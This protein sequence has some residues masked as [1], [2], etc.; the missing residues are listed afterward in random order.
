MVRGS[1]GAWPS[2]PRATNAACRRS[3]RRRLRRRPRP[4]AAGRAAPVG[5]PGRR[6]PRPPGPPADAAGRLVFVL[7]LLV[8][9]RARRRARRRLARRR[10]R[11]RSSTP[12]PSTTLM[13]AEAAA[14]LGRPDVGVP[15]LAG[16][17]PPSPPT[18]LFVVGPDAA[19]QDVL[20]AAGDP[21]QLIELAIYPDLPV[22]RV[23]RPGRPGLASRVACG[24]AA[25]STTPSPTRSTT[26]ST[27]PPPRSCSA[28]TSST[29]RSSLL[30]PLVQDAATHYDDPVE[31]TH[32][33]IDRFLPFDQRVL[34]RVYASPDRRPQRRRLR[35][36]H[37]R[38]HLPEGLLLS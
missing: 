7:G 3:P 36:L 30:P 26:R 21:P 19:V 10:G 20:A 15:G 37:H 16:R 38:R 13:T 33:L 25:R 24:A 31:V 32:V 11:R 14:Q 12:R 28:S 29:S 1:M 9:A 35:H 18:Q 27:R 23:P 5:P 8:T 2:T 17:R 34:V 4:S 6:S 22:R